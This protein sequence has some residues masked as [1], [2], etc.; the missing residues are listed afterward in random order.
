MNLCVDMALVPSAPLFLW[1]LLLLAIIVHIF[2][3]FSCHLG[4]LLTCSCPHYPSVPL[5]PF[6]GMGP[7]YLPSG[8]AHQT[9]LPF[10][11]S[12]PLVDSFTLLCESNLVENQDLIPIHLLAISIHIPFQELWF[13]NIL[14]YSLKPKLKSILRRPSVS[15]D[16]S[17][18]TFF[19]W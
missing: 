5:S 2:K 12:S 8:P 10:S 14:Q 13:Y 6:S 15:F 3:V 18:M 11:L 9:I 19:R 4:N 7:M 16:S 17:L 1:S